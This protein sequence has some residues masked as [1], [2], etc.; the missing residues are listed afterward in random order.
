MCESLLRS[1]FPLSS[2]PLFVLF[3]KQHGDIPPRHLRPHRDRWHDN[4]P[5]HM[6][7]LG[8]SSLSR[9]FLAFLKTEN[10]HRKKTTT[11]KAKIEAK[12]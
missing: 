2:L 5:H 1:L 11:H 12:E 9:P 6:V 10:K 7:K 3:Q 8:L 4:T